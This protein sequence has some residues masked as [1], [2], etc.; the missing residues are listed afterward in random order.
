MKGAGEILGGELGR[1]RARRKEREEEG[2]DMWGRAVSGAS[3]GAG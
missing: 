2:D 1:T 3:A